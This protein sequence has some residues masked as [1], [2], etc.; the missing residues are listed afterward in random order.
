MAKES[1]R[2]A[3]THAISVEERAEIT[4]LYKELAKKNLKEKKF[5]ENIF[6]NAS[7]LY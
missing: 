7:S 3:E 6:K 4:N 5:S 2:K 1:L